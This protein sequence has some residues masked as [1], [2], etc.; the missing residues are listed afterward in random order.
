MKKI[1]DLYAENLRKGN[2]QLGRSTKKCKKKW[3]DAEVK[4]L[5]IDY[6]NYV[7]MK[8]LEIKYGRKY[9]AIIDKAI[10]LNLTRKQLVYKASKLSY[11]KSQ[12]ISMYLYGFSSLQVAKLCGCGV[13]YILK[14]L[15]KS[16]IKRRSCN[17]PKAYSAHREL[18]V[19]QLLKI[20]NKK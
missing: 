10:R 8:V 13:A 19:N 3:T 1:Y 9:S 18:L 6:A 12:I 7:P 16:N 2:I 17:Y 5:R 15:K 14:V 11:T 20:Q 4:Q